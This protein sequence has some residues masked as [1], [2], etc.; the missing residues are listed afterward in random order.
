[1]I[2]RKRKRIRMMVKTIFGERNSKND[3]FTN[4]NAN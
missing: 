3:N 1:M 2:D 4:D